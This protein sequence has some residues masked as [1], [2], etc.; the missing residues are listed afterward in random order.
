[1]KTSE[2]TNEISA[3]LAKAQGEMRNPEKSRTAEY[4]TKAGG[5]V[6]YNYADLAT[7]FDAA[8]GALAKNGLAHLVTTGFAESHYTLFCRLTHVSGQWYESE[9]PLPSDEPKVVGAHITYG[10]RYLFAALTGMAPD[11]DMDAEPE[12]KG[13]YSARKP[14]AVSGPGPVGAVAPRVPTHSGPAPSDPQIKRLYTIM[15]ASGVSNQGMHAYIL[16]KWHRTSTR[17]LTMAEYDAVVAAMERGEV[18]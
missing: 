2:L 18:K 9:W 6:K 15:A 5:K 3:A 11:E 4:P 17:D 14:P 12:D 13:Q 10:T 8:R 7:C 16:N 1:M